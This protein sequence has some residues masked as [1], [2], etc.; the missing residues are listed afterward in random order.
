MPSHRLLLTLL[1]VVSALALSACA[2]AAGDGSV[3]APTASQTPA[4]TAPLNVQVDKLCS[5]QEAQI[6]VFVD[7]EPIGVTNPGESGVSSMVTVGE[8]QLSAISQRGTQWGPFPT[9]VNP[10]GRVE[11]LGCM[12]ADAL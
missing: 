7:R 9:T 4:L 3:I 8:H 6:R 2:G 1:G 11:R 5:G 10:G 12:P